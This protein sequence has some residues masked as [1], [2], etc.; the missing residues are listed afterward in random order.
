[1]KIKLL[2][3][4]VVVFS[5]TVVV[6]WWAAKVRL[7]CRCTL[8]LSIVFSFSRNEFLLRKFLTRQQALS[9]IHA[10]IFVRH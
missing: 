3:V 2:V 8:F 7:D 6:E 4:V 1:M 9:T 5:E 10:V